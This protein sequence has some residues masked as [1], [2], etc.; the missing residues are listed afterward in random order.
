MGA[1]SSKKEKPCRTNCQQPVHDPTQKV[2]LLGA[3]RTGKSTMYYSLSMVDSYNSVGTTGMWEDKQKLTER[4]KNVFE[5]EEE[6]QMFFGQNEKYFTK[7]KIKEIQQDDYEITK[8]DCLHVR[9]TTSGIGEQTVKFGKGK[10]PFQIVDVG[11]ARSNRKL[12]MHTFQDVNIVLY[13]VNLIDR[14]KCRGSSGD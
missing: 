6:E 2:L 3:G 9:I 10:I 14:S 12:W 11:G 7:E 5:D 13:F 4:I 1:R 8:E